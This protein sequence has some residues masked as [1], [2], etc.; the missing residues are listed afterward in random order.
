[1]VHT[2]YEV[3]MYSYVWSLQCEK[4][5]ENRFY[6][7]ILNYWPASLYEASQPASGTAKQEQFFWLFSELWP[8]KM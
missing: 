7:F 1:M 2:W 5:Q 4:V 3:I 6:I 8:S